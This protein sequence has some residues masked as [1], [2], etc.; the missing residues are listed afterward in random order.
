MK[1]AL[2]VLLKKRII[3]KGF[4]YIISEALRYSLKELGI[5]A[6]IVSDEDGGKANLIFAVWSS[7]IN[8]DKFEYDK[9]IHITSENLPYYENAHPHV[10]RMWEEKSPQLK[11]FD[12]IFE[13]SSQQV[14]FLN[15]Q[16]YKTVHFP[17]G[18]TPILDTWQH[19]HTD[20]SQNQIK[21]SF[22]GGRQERRKKIIRK[23]P[24][25]HWHTRKSSDKES[26]VAAR[27]W[28]SLNIKHSDRGCFEAGRVVCL[29]MGNRSFVVTEP[30][31]DD[32][33]FLNKEHLVIAETSKIPRVVKY[34]LA[35]PKE[36]IKIAEKG[37]DFVKNHYTMTQNLERALQCLIEI[38][39]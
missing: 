32:V 18:Y 16:G 34:Y 13:H 12:Y 10:Q 17:W 6:H 15:V 37:Y 20:H 21:V 27:S 11:K 22:I 39:Q 38:Q 19:G 1:T 25:V 26:D 3:N 9:S 23:I 8:L 29:A 24:D 14:K 36:R 33:P 7:G 31:E 2:I 28:I 5:D 4:S 35:H 30:F